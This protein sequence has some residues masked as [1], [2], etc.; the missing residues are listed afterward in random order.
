MLERL[1][2]TEKETQKRLSAIEKSVGALVKL[3][4]AQVKSERT[5]ER[6]AAAIARRQA[7]DTR[8]N[9]KTKLRQQK[10]GKK[11]EK[12]FIQKLMDGLGGAVMAVAAAPLV[13]KGLGLAAAGILT[14]ALTNK[15]V[16]DAM[17]GLLKEGAKIMGEILKQALQ[18]IAKIAFGDP[19]KQGGAA[20]KRFQ[21]ESKRTKER[22]DNARTPEEKREIMKEEKYYDKMNFKYKYM[23]EKVRADFAVLRAKQK[24]LE[25]VQNEKTKEEIDLAKERVKEEEARRDRVITALK[26]A[27]KD[28]KYKLTESEMEEMYNPLKA[29]QLKE[30]QNPGFMGWWHKTFGGAI[31][32][33]KLNAAGHQTGG[34]ITVPGSGSGDKMFTYVQPGSFVM[35]RNAA[36]FQTG[37]VPVMLEPGEHVYGPGQWGP[38]EMMMNQMIP[39]FQKGGEISQNLASGAREGVSASMISQG[40][41]KGDIQKEVGAA[42]ES[43]NKK[44]AD[45][46]IKAAEASTGIYRG[47]GEMC[48][49]TTRAVLSAAGH[50]GAN[51]LTTTADLDSPAG[52]GPSKANTALAGSFAGSDMGKVYNNPAQAPAGSVIMW[53]GTYGVQKWGPNAVTHVGIKGKGND[54]YHHGRGP[55]WRKDSFSRYPPNF[56]VDL[57]GEASGGGSGG[58]DGGVLGGLGGFFNDMAGKTQSG[59][60]EGM[61]KAG[62]PGLYDLMEIF[63]G[64]G[65]EVLGGLF[66]AIFGGASNFLSGFMGGFTGDASASQM[67]GEENVTN[68]PLQQ[69]GG[70]KLN[71]DKKLQ[72][73]GAPSGAFSNTYKGFYDMAQKAGAKYPELVA[74]QWQLESASGTALSGT[75][76]YFGIKAAKGEK[77][78]TKSTW[79]VLGGK[80]VTVNA[81]FKDFSHPQEAVNH[82]VGQWHKDYKGYKGVNNSADAYAAADALRQQGY[83]TDPAYSQKLKRIMK[84]NGYQSGGMVYGTSSTG[85]M[86]G[87]PTSNLQ[88]FGQAQKMFE[89]MTANSGQP[90]VVMGGGASGGGGG[91]VDV[92]TSSGT[93][94]PPNLPDGPNVVAL[95]ELTNRLAM[96]AAI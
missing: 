50:P 1:V 2:Q 63:V 36:G 95:L 45:A 83:A 86:R 92:Q 80:N 58:G 96:G 3:Q 94:G 15:K 17:F 66:G 64:T 76:N 41:N 44:G 7:S 5:K 31:D 40:T 90:I 85:S 56:A 26:E 19:S 38:A 42:E 46:I 62:L 30:I 81:K 68:M 91:G 47:V 29:A 73:S 34:P 77:G 13:I 75:H 49:V 89:Q 32:Y 11:E 52:Y 55:G 88:R 24:E 72:T 48:A 28:N 84:Q 4:S 87:K 18:G 53:R 14:F 22:I 78:S 57:N 12:N 6:R 39:R 9:L 10:E 33:D 70:G 69:A 20:S 27:N 82:L 61:Y 60:K 65:K 79:E 23:D 43:S 71:E 21:E 74:A 93:P 35:N 8:G 54:M 37:G 59:L 16:R 51:K 67:P 25:A